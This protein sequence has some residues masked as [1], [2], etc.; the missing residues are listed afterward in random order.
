[1]P[2]LFYEMAVDSHKYHW[3]NYHLILIL[4]FIWIESIDIWTIQ[5]SNA[6]CEINIMI[7]NILILSLLVDKFQLKID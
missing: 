5:R 2:N 7:L 1:M 3:Y 4:N 6:S